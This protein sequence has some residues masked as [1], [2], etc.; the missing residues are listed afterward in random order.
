MHNLE[1]LTPFDFESLSKSVLDRVLGVRLEIFK[2]GRD[3]GVDL[4]HAFQSSKLVVQCKHTPKYSA[5]R[6]SRELKLKELPKVEKLAV[7]RYVITTS[8]SLNPED[9]KKIVASMGRFILST[10]DVWG[11]HEIESFLDE[12]ESVVKAHLR[13]WLNSSA[14]LQAVLSQPIALRSAAYAAGI[15]A[16]LKTFVQTEAL[17]RAQEV[18]GR[19]RVLLISGHPGIGKTTLAD[20]LCAELMSDGCQLVK[21]TSNISEALELWSDE[22]PQVF[23][24]DDFLGRSAVSDQLGKNEDGDILSFA[25]RCAAS[26][27]SYF[28][29]TT[30]GYILGQARQIYEKLSSPTLRLSECVLELGD[31]DT[32]SRALILYNHVWAAGLSSSEMMEFA[33]RDTFL[34]IIRHKN[35]SPRL[36]ALSLTGQSN[37]GADPSPSKRM[38]FN[39]EHPDQLWKHAVENDLSDDARHLLDLFASLGSNVAASRLRKLW[40]DLVLDRN[41]GDRHAKALAE[42]EGDFLVVVGDASRPTLRT[43]NPSIDDFMNTRLRNNVGLVVDFAEKTHSVTHLRG[44]MRIFEAS[45][46]YALSGPKRTT[47]TPAQV[48]SA[49]FDAALRLC[50]SSVDL[51]HNFV[52]QRMR[53]L[54]LLADVARTAEEVQVAKNLVLEFAEFRSEQDFTVGFELDFDYFFD[55]LTA[56]SRHSDVAKAIQSTDLFELAAEALLADT[57]DW[58]LV[59]A[60]LERAEAIDELSDSAQTLEDLRFELAQEIISRWDGE[61]SS[62]VRQVLDYAQEFSNPE[63]AFENYEGPSHMVAAR[64]EQREFSSEDRFFN[65]AEADFDVDALMVGLRVEDD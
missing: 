23:L 21:V 61:D 3:G 19:K 17:K 65:A 63:E 48:Q 41:A 27:N 1:A 47:T 53:R 18:L 39:L 6:L 62:T 52:N 51:S 15:P 40:L 28:I 42:L 13:L 43:A 7:D 31:L 56:M 25:D 49:V 38:L 59:S 30:R 20:V 44:L 4:S 8:A 5:A 37:V 60:A 64:E 45:R 34:P 54:Q 24:Y 29:M 57:S 50:R 33:S 26:P 16:V 55:F 35:Y 2:P 9:K 36:I 10:D 32:E 58:N 46:S 12:N 11:R 22:Q 14:V